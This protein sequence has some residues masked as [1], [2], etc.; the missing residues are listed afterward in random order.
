MPNYSI[1]N[2]AALS[3]FNF[4]S[5]YFAGVASTPLTDYRHLFAIARYGYQ[6]IDFQE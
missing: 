5:Y 4:A 2:E 1:R 3:H 6:F